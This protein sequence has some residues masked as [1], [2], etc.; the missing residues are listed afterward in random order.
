LAGGVHP[1]GHHQRPV[2]HSTAGADLLDL[3]VQPQVG[4]ALS[5]GRS[6]KAV[7]CSSRPWQSLDT[8]SLDTPASPRAS[9]SRSTLRVD[10]PLT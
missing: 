2:L 9:T 5:K 3:G 4:E 7:T 8:W 1:V 6:A 10:T